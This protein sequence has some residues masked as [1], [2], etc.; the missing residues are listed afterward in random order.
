[1]SLSI[2]G[3]LQDLLAEKGKTRATKMEDFVENVYNHAIDG[4][5]WAVK[6][7]AERLEG[8]P[9]RQIRLTS[10]VPAPLVELKIIDVRDN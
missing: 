8:T 1:M 3:I 9:L 2:K 5:P 6:F 7:I 4:K 10:D